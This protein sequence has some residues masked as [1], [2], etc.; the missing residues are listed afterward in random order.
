M[1]FDSN[2]GSNRFDDRFPSAMKRRRR[3]FAA[4]R[5]R[6]PCHAGD[7]CLRD[8]RELERRRRPSTCLP[9]RFHRPAHRRT[10][11]TPLVDP[12][13][14]SRMPRHCVHGRRTAFKFEQRRVEPFALGNE[15]LDA[16]PRGAAMRGR[17]RRFARAAQ[18]PPPPR[19]MS[20]KAHARSMSAPPRALSFFSCR[21]L[22]SNHRFD[23]LVPRQHPSR[24]RRRALGACSG[25]R[26]LLE[27][28]AIDRHGI[29]TARPWM[30]P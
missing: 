25:R 8:F 17:P 16:P 15:P 27:P 3:E 2:H 13:C 20:R 26:A 29:R 21:T 5:L 23:Q 4:R 30:R 9:R 14:S 22:F 1:Y 19:S 28:S 6:N 7:H 12:V 18:R 11:L 10:M 24:A